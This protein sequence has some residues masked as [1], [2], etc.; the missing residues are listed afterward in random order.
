M[1]KKNKVQIT[2]TARKVIITEKLKKVI[3]LDEQDE[4]K[5]KENIEKLTEEDKKNL[6]DILNKMAKPLDD[7]VPVEEEE[8]EETFDPLLYNQFI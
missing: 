3:K 1:G 8:E 4:D 5:F 2:N 7:T 6:T